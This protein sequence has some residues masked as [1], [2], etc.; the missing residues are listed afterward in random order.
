LPEESKTVPA[1]TFNSFAIQHLHRSTSL[2]FNSFVV[3]QQL[4]RSTASPFPLRTPST[5]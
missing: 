5:D 1:F 2:P 4:H 3:V